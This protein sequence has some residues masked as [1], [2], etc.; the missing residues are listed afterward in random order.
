MKARSKK[1]RKIAELSATLPELRKSDNDWIERTF[2]EN[3]R[4]GLYYFVILERCKVVSG[5]PLLS[6][7]SR[8]PVGS[9]ADMVRQRRRICNSTTAFY[10][11]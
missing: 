4:K 7:I 9:N 8:S 5:Y 10:A 2:A 3:K 1:E 6:Q 11:C